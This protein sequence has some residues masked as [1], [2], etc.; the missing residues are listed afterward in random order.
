M[1]GAR[2]FRLDVRASFRWIRVRGFRARVGG[3]G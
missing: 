3:S 2:G 1:L